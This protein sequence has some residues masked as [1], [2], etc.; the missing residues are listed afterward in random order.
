MTEKQA[1]IELKN[2]LKKQ[3]NENPEI[4]DGIYHTYLNEVEE[5]IDL[6]EGRIIN[7]MM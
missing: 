4:P 7:I 2:W 5:E 1:L 6:L 3:I